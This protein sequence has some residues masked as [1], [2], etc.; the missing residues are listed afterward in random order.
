[1][2]RPIAVRPDDRNNQRLL[3]NT[4]PADW[5][6][7]KPRDRYDLVVIGA[8]TAGLI[9]A[10]IAAGL[11]ARVALVERELLGG[12]CLNYGCVPSKSLIRAARWIAEARRASALLGTGAGKPEVDFAAAMERVRRIRAQISRED[13]ARRY[14]DELGVAV[15]LG[16]ARFVARDSI[17]VDGAKLRFKKAVIA[18]GARAAIPALEGLERAGYLTNETV[19]ELTEP[20]ARLGVIGGGPIGAE[21]AQAFRRLGC[22]VAVFGRSPQL[23]PREDADASRLLQQQF[24]REGIDLRLGCALRRVE[25]RERAKRI[26]LVEADGT[27]ASVDVD[28]ILVATGRA[29]NVEGMNLEAA[30][31]AY[32]ESRGVH[33]DDTLRTDNPRI[34]AAGDV[35]MAWKFT[36]AAD[37]AAKIAVRNALFWRN[38]KLSSLVMPRCT[39]TDPEIAQVGLGA[40]EAAE[41]GIELASFEVPLSDVNRAVID[42]EELGFVK[43]HLAA[44]SDRILGATIVASHAG[45]LISEVTLAMTNGLG[46]GAIQRTIHPYPT[47]AEALKR[48]AGAYTRSRLTPRLRWL[49]ARHFSLRG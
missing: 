7:P 41:R 24:E 9:S 36:H 4:R 29:P 30:G 20:P 48:V 1:M 12:D 13:S 22:E 44:R 33:V 46:L 17:E 21:L 31:V 15:F 8:G 19:F 37:A 6:N 10:A 42:G 49:L 27:R 2:T 16:S 28:A 47:Q 43:L 34:Y 26:E 25:L 3:A 23:L 45:E 18:T 40:R 38:Q 32:D 14:R 39:Y 11:G 35:A 5:Q